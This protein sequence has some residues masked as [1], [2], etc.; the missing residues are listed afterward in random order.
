MKNFFKKPER[1]MIYFGFILFIISLF[2][3]DIKIVCGMAGIGFIFI[4]TGILSLL[5]PV[6]NLL[7]FSNAAI[8]KKWCPYSFI[9]TYRIF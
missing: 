9:S 3:P 8:Q 4:A 7:D 2:I 5:M 1:Y 6:K